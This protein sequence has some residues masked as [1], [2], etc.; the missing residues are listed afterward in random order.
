MLREHARLIVRL[1]RLLD[2]LLAA[3]AFVSAYFIKLYC[4][5]QELRGLIT[6]PNYYIVLLLVIIIWYPVFSIHGVYQSFRTQKLNRIHWNTFKALSCGI[7][8]LVM[9]MYAFKITDVSRIML[10]IFYGLNLAFL[11][12]SKT[13][14]YQVLKRFRSR[15]YNFR[16]VL[17]VGSGRGAE[18]I[19]DAIGDRLGAGYRI[20]GCLERNE[21]HIGM[22]VKNGVKVI[23]TYN[24]LEHLLME[25]VVDELIFATSLKNVPDVRKHIDL[26]EKTGV[27][28][29]IMPQWYI[30]RLGINPRVGM[31]RIE[32]FL[33]TPTMAIN[34]TPAYRGEIVIKNFIDYTVAAVVL[35]LAFP[36]WVL[37][38]AGIKLSSPGPVLFKQERAGQNGR[39]FTLYKFRTMAE[40]A[41][42]K[43]KNL[44]A[45]NESDGP[46]F[47]IKKD[48]RV[49]PYIGTFL[50]RTCLDELPQLINVLKG[51]LSIVGPRP[52]LASEVEKYDMW[53]RRRLSMKP[54]LTCLWQ[55]TRNR[56]KI[57]FA[58]WMKMD[59]K[60]IDNWSLKLDFKILAMTV[61]AVLTGSGR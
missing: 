38:A 5:P 8:I 9:A 29:R 55:C 19:I 18:D 36:F 26:A 4:L 58:E 57:C 32:E 17:I 33:G 13:I 37:I 34:C 54:G 16:N 23:G 11:W 24:A 3:G 10:G 28:V 31:L 2:V 15:G 43:R 45:L 40:H 14:I 35:I 47:K 12:T 60:Y 30:R 49:I 46:V 50:R 39:R 7:L 1:H 53:Q 6:A 48:P 25:E 21:T 22:K 27:T 56:N 61:L 41:E 20:I 42:E 52:P 51:E 44:E 59:L